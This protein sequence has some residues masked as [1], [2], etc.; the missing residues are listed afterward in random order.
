M[1]HR[2]NFHSQSEL[3]KLF[4]ENTPIAYIIMDTNFTIY[5]I[6]ESFAKLRKLDRNKVIGDK[7]YNI[8]NAGNRCSNCA[9]AKA[10]F[11]L[12]KAFVSRKDILPDGSTRYIDDYAIPLQYREDG[13]VEFVLEIMIDRTSEALTR[14]QYN[15]DF[16]EIL[17]ILSSLI[18]A[19]DSY[20]AE[21]SKN[22]RRLSLNLGKQL[23]LSPEELFELSVAA[24]LHDIGKIDIPDDIINKPDRLTEEEF[25][26]VK[27]HSLNSYGILERFPSF[28]HIR[29]IALHHH[30]RIDG[31]GYPD[32]LMGDD[33]PLGARI[34][35]VAD[36]YDAITTARSYKK[37]MSHSYALEELKR[38]AGTQLDKPLVEAFI[39]IDFDNMT[40]ELYGIPIKKRVQ[41]VE[42][43]IQD[44]SDSLA[45]GKANDSIL[46]C[47]D[48]NNL[49]NE[50]LKNTPCGYIL[51]DNHYKVCYASDYFLNYMGLSMD[52]ILNQKCYI[53]GNNRPLPCENCPVE[54]SLH[55]GKTE[56][57]RR[58]QMTGTGEK[59]FDLYSVPLV[60]SDSSIPYV[61]EII[62]DR[63]EEVR[64]ESERLQDFEK[65]IRLLAELSDNQ[66][67][68]ICKQTLSK[69]IISLRRRFQ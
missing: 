37:A 22:V 18:E 21:H 59:T 65:I 41:Q 42:R 55:N 38:S 1:D 63:T 10:F 5:Y 46:S 6:N 25:N 11:S 32:G 28:E 69:Y 27:K 67:N 12:E 13:S 15:K 34:V 48:L 53:A 62:I 2:L 49:L 43:V 16:D 68:E 24:S 44:S 66:E 52:N 4:I 61:I 9:V 26:I 51:L 39:H 3:I 57:I 47:F 50:I 23:N 8:S 40:E 7:C 17:S 31:N 36:S 60:F 30:E 14:E 20:T 35:A 29:D 54:R 56:Y 33:I 58:T 64:I 19:K 45:K